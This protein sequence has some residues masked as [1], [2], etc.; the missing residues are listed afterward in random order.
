MEEDKLYFAEGQIDGDVYFILIDP[1]VFW[2]DGQ[3][4]I[5][6][7][8]IASAKANGAKKIVFNDISSAL[9]YIV[10][11]DE[12]LRSGNNEQAVFLRHNMK[13]ALENDLR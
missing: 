5:E 10:D 11:I 8:Y 3:G 12:A 9:V 1:K 4:M 2:S 6:K 7:Q 13:P